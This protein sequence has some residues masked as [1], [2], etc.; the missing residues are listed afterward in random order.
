MRFDC[1]NIRI[2]IFQN[3]LLLFSEPAVNPKHASKT[4]IQAPSKLLWDVDEE[5]TDLMKEAEATAKRLCDNTR[6]VLLQTDVYGYR[7]IKEVGKG[8][9]C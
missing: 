6:S 1:G 4:P 3:T 9:F 7:Y 8:Q 2:F 5:A